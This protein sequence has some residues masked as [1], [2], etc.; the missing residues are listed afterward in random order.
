MFCVVAFIT[1]AYQVLVIK[2]QLRIFVIVLDVMY[3]L[4]FSL[5]AVSLAPLALISVTSQDHCSF[6]FPDFSLQELC[7]IHS[8]HYGIPLG[9]IERYAIT[10]GMYHLLFRCVLPPIIQMPV[11]FILTTGA[12]C[13]KVGIEYVQKLKRYWLQRVDS[14]H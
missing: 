2:S 13:F 7:F 14:D 4:R 8:H 10:G 5:S 11:L 12:S 3:N 9:S 6:M 1:E